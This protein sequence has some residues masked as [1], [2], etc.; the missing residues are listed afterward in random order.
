MKKRIIYL[1]ISILIVFLFIVMLN[2]NHNDI[3]MKDGITYAI[4]IN[5]ITAKEFPEKGLYNVDV[6]CENAECK[7]DY[8]AWQ[9][10]ISNITGNIS[11][12]IS[13]N[14]IEKKYL[15]DEII[16]LE[17][18][19]RE[20]GQ[21]VHETF[22][23]PIKHPTFEATEKF[24]FDDYSK[25]TND[26]NYPWSWDE[27]NK[28]YIHLNEGDL[29]TLVVSK[30]KLSPNEAG[31]YQICYKKTSN[32]NGDI[33]VI[34]LND[35]QIKYLEGISINSYECLSLPN[36][37]TSDVVKIQHNE[38]KFIHAEKDEVSFYFQKGTYDE[39]VTTENF[40]TGY[41]YEGENPNNYIKF[42]NEIWRII[43]VFDENSHGVSNTFLTK[44]IKN[45]SSGSLIFSFSIGHWT[46]STL[47]TLL[48]DYYY[49]SINA[50]STSYCYYSYRYSRYYK[51]ICNYQSS[52]IS[53]N[54]KFMIKPVTW[55]LG[56]IDSGKKIFENYYETNTN[57]YYRFERSDIKKFYDD[58]PLS[59][60]SNIGLIYPSDYGY[61]VL[62]KD[63]PRDTNLNKYSD[64]LCYY[65]NWMGEYGD[66]WTITPDGYYSE[67]EM[68][69][70]GG[71]NS[72]HKDPKDRS[73]IYP[74][75]YLNENVYVLDGD[76]SITNPYIIAMDEA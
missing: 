67:S 12:G 73:G 50:T 49:N 63:C 23:A 41:R 30:I 47:K 54:Y 71:G 26:E 1:S 10:K 48:N 32:N 56:A 29:N 38:N 19:V 20:G 53:E 58:F 33:L 16:K 69:I 35:V 22:T 11:C 3:F 25:V 46:N 60:I 4:N 59:D 43:G 61:S 55:F 57:Q 2:N 18:Q 24:N 39:N 14:S 8:E 70:N 27:T 45:S 66:I 52:G 36:L 40:D 72:Y 68:S 64:S 15:N 51:T 21:V 7:W 44:I 76:G 9:L 62:E 17:G 37:K 42:N 28:K 34:S 13:F 31:N 5:G 74:T 6:I 75:L 65:K